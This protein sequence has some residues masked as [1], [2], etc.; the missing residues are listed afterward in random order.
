[1]PR[2][3]PLEEKALYDAIPTTPTDP[4]EFLK[5]LMNQPPPDFNSLAQQ[6]LGPA[7]QAQLDAINKARFSAQN[8]AAYSDAQ[9]AAMY[10]ALGIDIGKNAANINN[11]YA[12]S[13][14]DVNSAYTTGK[15]DTNAVYGA[16]QAKINALLSKLGIGAAAPDALAQSTTNQ[17]LINGIL[18]ANQQA[19]NNSLALSKQG[20]LSFNTAQQNIASLEGNNR[21]SDLKQ[22][23]AKLLSGYDQQQV[24]AA[25]NYNSQLADRQYQMQQSYLQQQQAQQN[26]MYNFMTDQ[27]KLQMQQNPTMAQQWNMMGPVDKGYYQASQMFGPDNAG[28]AVSLVMGSTGGAFPEEALKNSFTFTQEILRRNQEL[29]KINPAAAIPLDQEQQ[30]MSL[31]ASMFDQLNPRYNPYS[32]QG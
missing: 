30:L 7:Y 16:G 19:A 10:K 20:D 13:Q 14:K 26:S 4:M 8:Q 32:N 17:A 18:N 15:A 11:N 23:L 21:R 12:Q 25:G 3:G 29:A 31:A 2:P 28:K 24:Q 6:Q 27:Q 9:L 5:Q 22:N 1:M